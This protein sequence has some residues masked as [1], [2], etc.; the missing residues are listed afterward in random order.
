MPEVYLFEKSLLARMQET[1]DVFGAGQTTVSASGIKN[2]WGNYAATV[3]APFGWQ[4][5]WRIP[6]DLCEQMSISYPA[7]VKGT[8]TCV[9]WDALTAMFCI[10]KTQ[11]KNVLL[12]EEQNP[13]LVDL[14]PLKQNEDPDAFLTA[15]CLD[16][17]RFFY[18]HLW[19]PW[20]NDDDCDDW[21]EK[22]LE[23]RIRFYDDLK[24]NAMSKR[25]H[26]HILALLD[27]AKYLQS[28]LERLESDPECLAKVEVLEEDNPG[29]SLPSIVAVRME[30]YRRIC[31]IKDDIDVLEIPVL[32]PLYERKSFPKKT[33]AAGKVINNAKML[34]VVT[35]EGTVKEQM[36]YFEALKELVNQMPVQGY[37]SLQ[38]ALE[39]CKSS[40]QIVLPTGQHPINF[41]DYLDQGS[42][43]AFSS[44]RFVEND[45]NQLPELE[46]YISTVSSRH[47]D[48]ILI[49]ID[50]DYCFENI[51]LNCANVAVGVMIR[52]GNVTFKNCCII[53]DSQS[54]T[55]RGIVIF[56]GCNVRFESCVIK[57]FPVGICCSPNCTIN[58]F[59][60]IVCNCHNGIEALEDCKI[61]FHQSGIFNCFYYGITLKT[62]DYRCFHKNEVL[63]SCNDYSGL[64][65]PEFDFEGSCRFENNKKA[66]FVV[67]KVDELNTFGEY[68]SDIS[69]E[70]FLFTTK[71]N[72]EA[73]SSSQETPKKSEESDHEQIGKTE[74]DEA[75]SSRTAQRTEPQQNEESACEQNKKMESSEVNY[76]YPSNIEIDRAL[77][78][79]INDREQRKTLPG[80]NPQ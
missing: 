19:M 73:D 28:K 9:D 44:I 57:D 26:S 1:A 32:R 72:E 56:A 66:N 68:L 45:L 35:R 41:L 8:V 5:V 52:G 37:D 77:R 10:D 64:E 27:E 7:L 67:S 33:G 34:K 38:T 55:K 48:S 24:M 2:E 18:Q 22:H 43:V 25:L 65:R 54:S 46:K 12:V 63:R 71:H 62:T 21:V 20:D 74:C 60:S 53:G 70:G 23:S 76:V 40:G 4:A 79:M 11:N 47:D 78:E 16:K 42:L 29:V 61:N 80:C 14:W 6:R 36:E 69:C 31:S 17:M 58:L 51:L 59:D 49:R 3:V 39:S 50:G 30:I 15:N 13:S 75:H